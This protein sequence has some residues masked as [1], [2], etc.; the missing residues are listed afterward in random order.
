MKHKHLGWKIFSDVIVILLVVS[1]GVI[2]YV[3]MQLREQAF[4]LK[5]AEMKPLATTLVNR[6]SLELDEKTPNYEEFIITTRDSYELE[7]AFVPAAV[8]SIEVPVFF[9]H[10]LEDDF[11]PTSDTVELYQSKTNGDCE[12]W[13]R[14]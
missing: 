1:I 6:V 8:A 10:G 7:S 11:I 12:L 3:S 4:F 9:I 13:S 14:S 2:V 5:L